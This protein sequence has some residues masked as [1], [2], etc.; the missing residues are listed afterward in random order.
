M[1][2]LLGARGE[3]ILTRRGTAEFIE[4]VRQGLYVRMAHLSAGDEELL[5]LGVKDALEEELTAEQGCREDF[6][7]VLD[8]ADQAEDVRELMPIQDRLRA[9]AAD[10]FSRRGSVAAY[11]L[12]RTVALDRITGAVLRITLSQMAAGGVGVPAGRW[13]WMALGAAGRGE[14]SRFDAC[15][16]LLVHEEIE[17]GSS[18][19]GFSGRPAPLLE[20]LSIGSRA[21]ITPASSSWRGSL[22]EWRQ[23]IAARAVEGGGDMEWLVRLADLRLVAGDPSLA[24]EMVNLVRSALSVQI[25]PLREIARRTAM[26][27]SGF[28]FFG[29]LRLERGM[30]NLALYGIGP[31]VANVRIM[32]VRFDIQETATT[33]RIRGLLYQGRIDVELAERLLRAWNCFYRHG[34]RREI[35]GENG[36]LVDTE[37]FGEDAERELHASLEAVGSLQKI[38][39]SSISGQG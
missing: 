12:M 11:H 35:A 6:S 31:L 28:D 36:I 2:L 32:T 27:Q 23:R 37:E 15:D 7:R 8:E 30:F 21:G 3:D 24:A 5:L 22:T 34:I 19:V 1:A 18:F 29:R 16:F 33:E 4:Q 17:A 39:Y 14:V 26:M 13:C 25:D 10:Y 9:M 20:R 38:V